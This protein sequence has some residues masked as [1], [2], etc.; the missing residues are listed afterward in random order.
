MN[1]NLHLRSLPDSS[2]VMFVTN[3]MTIARKLA[4]NLDLKGFSLEGA[5]R[6]FIHENLT[7]ARNR[8]FWMVKQKTKQ[9]DYK[10]FWTMNGNI[11]ARK[12]TDSNA[13]I[14]KAE[15]ELDLIK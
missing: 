5:Q 14:I 12:H 10:C 1:R 15:K 2:I 13:L 4:H 8:L 9:A 6:I 11:Y 3:F 7:Q